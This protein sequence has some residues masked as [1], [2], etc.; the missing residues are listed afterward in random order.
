MVRARRNCSFDEIHESFVSLLVF[1]LAASEE[2]SKF[3]IFFSRYL[4][5]SCSLSL[6]LFL[7][8]SLSYSLFCFLSL[9]ISLS[10]SLFCFLSLS[11]AF[12]FTNQHI[13]RRTFARSLFSGDS[14]GPIPIS[15]NCFK[16]QF[17][18]MLFFYFQELLKETRRSERPLS[19]QRDS[20]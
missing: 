13:R 20:S 17:I 12:L 9:F 7:F 8:I 19:V 18:F 10:Y 14:L 2:V 16:N 15:K 5:D 6:L 4:F 3:I 11:P 1:V